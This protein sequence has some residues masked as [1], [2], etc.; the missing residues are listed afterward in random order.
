MKHRIAFAGFRHPHILALWHLVKDHPDCEI[1]GTFEAD[2]A[3]RTALQVNE[4]ISITHEDL[5]D[6]LGESGCD[7]LAIGD[8]FAKRGKIAIKALEANKHVISD[9]PIATSLSDLQQISDLCKTKR[10][11]FGCQLDL[12]EN[13]AFQTLRESILNGDIGEVCTINI[14]AQHSLRFSSR[15]SWYFEPHQHGG[16]IN[17]I[18]IHVFDLVPWLTGLNWGEIIAAREWNAKAKAARHFGD[19]AQIFASLEGGATCFA[20]LSYHAPDGIDCETSLSW[21]TTIHGTKGVLETCYNSTSVTI[22]SDEDRVPRALPTIQKTSRTHLD[23]FLDEISGMP[24]IDGLSTS[25]I[26][27]GSQM[28]LHAQNLAYSV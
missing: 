20:D 15:P 11:V 16:T 23:D 9:K 25:R 3:T 19:C 26:L 14:L 21:R 7:I 10:L 28:A 8:V 5:D 24:S 12:V 6:L 2:A 27:A 22:I 1:V 4:G 18:G 13:S 17:D